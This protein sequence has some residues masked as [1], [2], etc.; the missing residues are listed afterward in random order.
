MLYRKLNLPTAQRAMIASVV[1]AGAVLCGGVAS[2]ASLN[3]TSSTSDQQR[4]QNIITKGNEEIM[5]RFNTLGRL[6]TKINDAQHLTQYDKSTLTTEVSTTTSGLTTLKGQ[7]DGATKVAVARNDANDIYTEYRVYYL[8]APKVYLIKVADDQQ[9]VQDKLTTMSGKLQ[10]RITAEQKAGKD[11]TTL[12]NDLNNMNNQIAAA[13]S[14]SSKIESSTI[15]LTPTDYNNDHS[16]LSGDNVQLKNAHSD[17]Q[18]AYTD[19]KNIV[20]ILKTM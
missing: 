3:T 6:T 17:D 11:V 18:A 1:L 10:A 14:I 13:H 15:N 20:S 7:L 2:A 5:R 4:L 9:V 16:I 12:Q 8:V 19:A